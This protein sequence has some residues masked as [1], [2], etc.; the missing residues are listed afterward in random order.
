MN[1]SLEADHV[2]V[3]IDLVQRLAR[4]LHFQAADIV[5]AVDDLPLQVGEVHGVE[6]DDPDGAHA[7]RR[8]IEHQRRA[9][10]ARADAEHFRRLQPLLAFEVDL[11]QDQVAAVAQDLVVAQFG[12]RA[13]L[14]G[15]DADR[16]RQ[17]L[18]R[19]RA[20]RDAR[21]DAQ[22]VVVADRR[23][24]ALQGTR[25]FGAFVDVHEVTQFALL[26]EQM[27]FQFRI[28][29]RQTVQYCLHGRPCDIQFVR[30]ACELLQRGRNKHSR[31]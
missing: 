19:P 1:C 15:D 11:R 21:H 7:R 25:V 18:R 9:Q 8:Q 20:A 22:F 28:L 26:I 16:L 13:A 14:V 3:R 31:H 12:V 6:I 2:D 30:S 24:H 23:R 10:P 4:R 27:F 17:R 29:R 5:G